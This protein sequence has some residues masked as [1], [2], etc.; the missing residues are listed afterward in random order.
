MLE[1]IEGWMD[2]N[3]YLS[4]FLFSLTYVLGFIMLLDQRTRWIVVGLLK[5]YKY[6]FF[7]IISIILL[8]MPLILAPLLIFSPIFI[9]LMMVI[10]F[11]TSIYF[12]TKL[13][14][15]AG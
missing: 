9:G 5:F 6:N 11:G 8:T 14:H 12:T 1:F 7:I 3:I 15:S 10:M 2:D 13:W 4:I